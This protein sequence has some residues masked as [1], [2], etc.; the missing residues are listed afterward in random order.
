MEQQH[1]GL[2]GDR[3][4]NLVSDLQTGA[5]FE[6]LLRHEDGDVSRQLLSILRRQARGVRDVLL[7]DGAPLGRERTAQD[8]L[9][10]PTLRETQRPIELPPEHGAELLARTAEPPTGRGPRRRTEEAV[11]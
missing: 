2:R 1:A 3:D 9:A 5:P 11:V 8:R 10:A 4:P 6:V 7:D